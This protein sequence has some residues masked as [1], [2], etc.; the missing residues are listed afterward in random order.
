VPERKAEQ[1]LAGEWCLWGPGAAPLAGADFCFVHLFSICMAFKIITVPLQDGGKAEAEL[2]GFLRS[3]KV[4]AVDRRWVDQ[5]AGFF[6]CFC[7]D[8]LELSGNGPASVRPGIATNC[9]AAPAMPGSA[10][11]AGSVSPGRRPGTTGKGRLVSPGR[12]PGTSG[13][14]RRG[15]FSALKGPFGQPRPTAWD[16][17]AAQVS[18][19]ERAVPLS[20]PYISFIPGDFVEP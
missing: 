19:P 11:K 10:C 17:Q 2:N 20:I 3:H 1:R 5:G 13:P 6:W 15:R 16:D 8:Y 14:T 18:G 12:R 7:I 4:L 9:Y